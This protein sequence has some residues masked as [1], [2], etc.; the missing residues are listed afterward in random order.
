MMTTTHL[1]V[2]NKTSRLGSDINKEFFAGTMKEKSMAR[3]VGG[4]GWGDVQE[5]SPGALIFAT[6]FYEAIP[7]SS[8]DRRGYST[9]G[10][11]RPGHRRWNVPSV[12]ETYTR[13][14]EPDIGSLR[15]RYCCDTKRD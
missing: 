1:N 8:R 4:G 13:Q 12:I 14:T 11:F 3:A 10:Q 5:R 15:C 9:D 2:I 6:T 7:V